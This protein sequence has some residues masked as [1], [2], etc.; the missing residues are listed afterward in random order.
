MPKKQKQ[1]QQQN[2]YQFN[3]N[4]LLNDCKCFRADSES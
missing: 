2:T 1:Q 4:E 3:R